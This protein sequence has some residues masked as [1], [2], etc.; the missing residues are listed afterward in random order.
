MK[1]HVKYLL[2][3]SGFDKFEYPEQIFKNTQISD[4]MKIR[5]VGAELF[6]T[7]GRAERQTG[8]HHKPS[9]REW[10][11][12]TNFFQPHFTCWHDQYLHRILVITAV[13][14]SSEPPYYVVNHSRRYVTFC[15]Q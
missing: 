13:G 15:S 12:V 3:L 1:L 5:L 7:V 10:A 2:F 11:W 9:S 8:R 4:I 6:H 14:G